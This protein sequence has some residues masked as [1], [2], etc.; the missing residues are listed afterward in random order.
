M[1]F[2]DKYKKEFAENLTNLSRE[3]ASVALDQAEQVEK[4]VNGYSGFLYLDKDGMPE[5][6]M[7]TYTHLGLADAKDEM[8]RME[9]LND[10]RKKL[11]KALCGSRAFFCGETLTSMVQ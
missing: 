8:I 6:A 9:E 11:E 5:V 7:K 1:I 10:A 2:I 3:N 4:F